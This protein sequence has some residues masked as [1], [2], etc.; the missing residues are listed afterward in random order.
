[1]KNALSKTL[2]FLM[3]LFFAGL[4]LQGAGVPW[5]QK[6]TFQFG[7]DIEVQE[8]LKSFASLQG[9][10]LKVS[11]GVSGT[12]NGS[13]EDISPEEF[14]NRIA[15]A[16]NLSWFYDGNILWVNAAGESVTEL[17]EIHNLAT[18]NFLNAFEQL[19]IVAPS[20]SIRILNDGAIVLISGPPKFVEMARDMAGKLTKETEIKQKTVLNKPIVKIF[21]LK[22]AWA[23][24]VSFNTEGNSITV[25][26]VAT[27]L[28][29]LMDTGGG[30]LPSV[31]TGQN[32]QDKSPLERKLQKMR[33]ALSRTEKQGDKNN[34][35]GSTAN[36]PNDFDEEGS[37]AYGG[38]GQTL[39]QPDIRLNAIIIR[40]LAENMPFYEE[41]ISTL[42]VPTTIIE[43]SAAIVDINSTFSRAIAN[44]FI[45]YNKGSTNITSVP[46][47]TNIQQLAEGFNIQ[48]TAVVNG[49]SFLA[50]VQALQEDGNA[51]ILARPS[52]ITLN[53]IEANISRS[54]TFYV[55]LLA[56]RTADLVNVT[57]GTTMKVTPRLIQEDDGTNRIKLLLTIEDGTIDAATGGAIPRTSNNTITTQAIVNEN[58]SLLIGGYYRQS[59]NYT[60]R[61]IP[62]LKDIPLLGRLFKS[63]S[64]SNEMIERMFL[65]TPRIIDL[66]HER[67]PDV[68]ACFD[69]PYEGIA[70][71]RIY[72]EYTPPHSEDVHLTPGGIVNPYDRIDAVQARC[73]KPG[74]PIPVKNN[75][76]QAKANN[77][78]YRDSN[79]CYKRQGREVVVDPRARAQKCQNKKSQRRF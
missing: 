36:D 33:G 44:G 38:I 8:L 16:Y 1:M 49:I 31:I 27:T 52:V 77:T 5:K 76:S 62:I 53:N 71:T 40:D 18:D 72:N 37:L 28:R 19:G 58:Q 13:F 9:I 39:I 48:A 20:S 11:E 32:V 74:H 4:T 67:S 63:S 55:Q 41:I 2:F 73:G 7:K 24:D 26:G 50:Q 64:K 22:Y 68:K 69:Q 54:E 57:V 12:V 65:I 42:D 25:P 10:N 45:N 15:E 34:E 75:A 23:Y 46:A 47:G 60:D 29:G 21:P 51:E 17:L 14:L 43:I 3:M 6:K 79:Y 59:N 78:Q 70:G 35:A 61:G 56:E 66:N 30:S